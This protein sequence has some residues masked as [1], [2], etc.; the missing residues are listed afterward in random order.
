MNAPSFRKMMG[1][2][3][4]ERHKEKDIPHASCMTDNLNRWA[5][6]IKE[7]LDQ[8]LKVCIGSYRN[9]KNI[10]S[11]SIAVGCSWE[12][13][14]D[15]RRLDIPNHDRLPCHDSAF[16]HSWLGASLRT[17][18]IQGAWQSTHWREHIW[19]AVWCHSEIQHP[20]QGGI[21]ISIDKSKLTSLW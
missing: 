12:S 3:R 13:V 2:Q 8:V 7:H 19:R 15:F 5:E 10:L 9:T 20:G 14:V 11:S 1:Y 18:L 4:G 6:Q 16:L 17:P 21:Q